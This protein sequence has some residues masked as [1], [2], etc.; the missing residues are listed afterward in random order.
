MLNSN[1]NKK[2]NKNI[3]LS[4]FTY[5]HKNLK[6]KNNLNSKNLKNFLTTESFLFSLCK[7][8]TQNSKKNIICKSTSRDL[9]SEFLKKN[10]LFVSSLKNTKGIQNSQN[11]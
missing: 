4:N 8:S 1:K 5:F 10:E 7:Q 3:Y 2:F 9:N 6:E 11:S